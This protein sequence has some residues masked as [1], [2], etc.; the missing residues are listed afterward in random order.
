[1]SD[2]ETG[3]PLHKSAAIP[4]DAAPEPAHPQQ[5]AGDPLA[6]LDQRAHEAFAAVAERLIPAA[7]GMP[8]A[9]EVV[10]EDRLRFV[11]RS[12]PDLLEPLRAALRPDLGADAAARLAA[13][14]GDEPVNLAALQLV[15]VGGYYT[16]PR[17][18]QLIG[19]PGQMAIEVR[20]W[21]YPPYMEEG[22]I[23]AVMARGPVWRDPATGQRALDDAAPRSYQERT[24][25]ADGRPEGGHDG[26]DG[27]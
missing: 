21:E 3:A 18:K 8:S 12:R 6:A 22:L 23:D 16:D 10:T 9:A 26:R 27:S 24:W 5:P 19:Y 11:L 14:E 25:S 17:V 13:L 7:H 4:A 15:I 1:M 20:S 2:P